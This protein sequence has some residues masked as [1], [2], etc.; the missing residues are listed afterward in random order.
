MKIR[1]PCGAEGDE[2]VDSCIK[3]SNA[4]WCEAHSRIAKSFYEEIVGGAT[5]GCARFQV[6]Y[7]RLA[8]ALYLPP[9]SR[10]TLVQDNPEQWPPNCWI[11]VEHPDLSELEEGCTIPSIRPYWHRETG[12]PKFKDWGGRR[13]NE[14]PNDSH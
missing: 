5:M 10:I 11:Y 12:P 4:D 13:E 7:Q 1:L 9:G 6:N 14:H 8:E 3:C 2:E